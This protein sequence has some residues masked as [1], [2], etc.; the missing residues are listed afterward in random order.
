MGSLTSLIM[1]FSGLASLAMYTGVGG[2]G[3]VDRNLQLTAVGA[4]SP[5]QGRGSLSVGGILVAVKG[6]S[7]MVVHHGR[8]AFR[9][10]VLAKASAVPAARSGRWFGF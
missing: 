9:V 10:D 7:K 6:P 4:T 3:A 2:I 1:I 8:V 5:H